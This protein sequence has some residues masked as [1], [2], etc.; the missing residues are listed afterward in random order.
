MPNIQIKIC[1]T[2]NLADARYCAALGVD[3][4]GF[5]QYPASP[6]YVEP[7]LAQEIIEWVEGPRSVGVFVNEDPDL[8]NKIASDTEFDLVQLHGDETPDYCSLIEKP[9]IKAIRVK[10]SDTVDQIRRVMRDYQSSVSSFLL[11]SFVDGVPGGTGRVLPWRIAATV[12]QDYPVFLA[13][14]LGPDNVVEAVETVRPV[15]IDVASGV[16]EAP[17]RK[18]FEAI[19]RLFAALTSMQNGTGDAA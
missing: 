8:V 2:T 18:S 9:V 4:L 16:E 5:I 15:G 17:G 6:R 13:G 14:G 11:D 3:Y 1:G 12:S 10:A 19:D 7:A